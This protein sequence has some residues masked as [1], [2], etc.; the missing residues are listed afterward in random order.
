MYKIFVGWDENEIEAYHVLAHSIIRHA[1]A[2]VSITPI[3]L[4][5]LPLTRERD[6]YQS[7]EFSFSRFLVP[8][9]C[10]Y[11]GWAV[12]MDVDMMVTGDIVE[13]FQCANEKYAVQCVQH[14][15]TPSGS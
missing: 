15:Y 8:W 11:Q 2:P 14:N 4:S 1:S 6:E 12:F 7:T 10:N 5:Q 3:K 9:M 13:L